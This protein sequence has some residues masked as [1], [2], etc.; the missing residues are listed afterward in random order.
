[1]GYASWGLNLGTPESEPVTV[2]EIKDHLLIESDDQDA[3]IGAFISAARQHVENYTNRILMPVDVELFFDRFPI[4]RDEIHLRRP[5]L[6]SF[7]RIRYLDSAG[8][9][10]TMP[11]EEYVVRSDVE[12]ARIALEYERHWPDAPER[13]RAVRVEYQAGYADAASVPAAIKAAIKLIVGDLME[14]REGKISMRV[15]TNPTIESLLWPYRVTE[16]G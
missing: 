2:Q 14:H 4:G 16:I 3:L 8:E 10:Q 5:P 9:L 6:I 13:P 12:P 15:Q 1:M 7:T 11:A